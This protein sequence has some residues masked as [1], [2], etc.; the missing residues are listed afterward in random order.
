MSDEQT[1][2][3]V[4][5]WAERFVESLEQRQ[6]AQIHEMRRAYAAGQADGRAAGAAVDPHSPKAII[7][8][9]YRRRARN[10][11]LT[12]RQHL[13]DIGEEAREN[14]IRVAKVAYDKRRKR[15]KKG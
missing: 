9:Y 12:L 10:P 2:E 1:E 6:A 13:R 5:Q 7:E 14:N 8:K 3:E 11:K 15:G 4:R